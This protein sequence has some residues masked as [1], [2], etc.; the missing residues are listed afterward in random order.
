MHSNWHKCPQE[1][2]TISA[3]LTRSTCS[4][5]QR[6]VCLSSKP[7]RPLA[8]LLML[9]PLLCCHEL[10]IYPSL[11]SSSLSLTSVYHSL[12]PC[13]PVLPLL[14]ILRV[15]GLSH[16]CMGWPQ[17]E[18]M[19]PPRGGVSPS[20]DRCATFGGTYDDTYNDHD[21]FPRG[22][23]GAPSE[24]DWEEWERRRSAMRGRSRS[25]GFEDGPQACR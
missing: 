23:G 22:R 17:P 3:H 16:V 18:P 20:D 2:K 10:E 25:P 8:P 9:S 6:S 14:H 15:S 11:Y 19:L 1:T 12:V 7:Q 21:G 5:P 13:Q 4:R 24:R